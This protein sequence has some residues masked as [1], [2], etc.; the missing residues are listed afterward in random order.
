MSGL[1]PI[2]FIWTMGCALAF[3]HIA[4]AQVSLPTVNLGDTNF[5]DGIAGPRLLAE[6]FPDWMAPRDC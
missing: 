2:L 3:P 1:T 6:E 5:E 4:R